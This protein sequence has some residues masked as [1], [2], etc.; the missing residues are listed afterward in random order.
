MKSKPFSC[1]GFGC[2]W[3]LEKWHILEGSLQ[4]WFLPFWCST[5]HY[6]ESESGPVMGTKPQPAS[7]SALW[8][9]LSG[10]WLT[11]KKN[12]KNGED[13]HKKYKLKKA[14]A[15][16]IGLIL[17]H[18][19]LNHVDFEADCITRAR[20]WLSSTG[21]SMV[22][23]VCRTG[24]MS[25]H[26]TV[27]E[28]INRIRQM[29]EWLPCPHANTGLLSQNVIYFQWKSINWLSEVIKWEL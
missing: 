11:K 27:E 21:H 17:F 6:G 2:V 4:S 29:T 20:I 7:V 13:N 25:T 19:N 3:S 23:Y 9:R 12:E 16:N 26:A 1:L 24:S 22:I 28:E 5:F 14:T 8:T 15:F 10:A 18:I